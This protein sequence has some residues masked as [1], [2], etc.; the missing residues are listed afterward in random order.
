[1]N[2]CPKFS[3]KNRATKACLE[4]HQRIT[5][6]THPFFVL[7]PPLRENPSEFLDETYAAKTRGMWLLYGDICMILTST[8]FD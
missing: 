8:V 1:M 7:T 5:F 6:T 4:L 3:F 2:F